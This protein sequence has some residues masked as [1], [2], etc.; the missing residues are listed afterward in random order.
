MKTLLR[1]FL[2]RIINLLSSNIQDVNTGERIGRALLIPWRGRIVVLGEGVAGYA[3]VPKFCPQKRITFWKC[4]LG[5][6]QHPL[7]DYPHEPRA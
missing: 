6:T 1:P 7:P 5:F 3:L 4:E 2:L